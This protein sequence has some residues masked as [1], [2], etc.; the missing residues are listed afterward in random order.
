MTVSGPERQHIAWLHQPAYYY[1]MGMTSTSSV[2][3]QNQ[4]TFPSGPNTTSQRYR[5]F[6]LLVI[7]MQI[8]LSSLQKLPRLNTKIS[9]LLLLNYT[10]KMA[11]TCIIKYFVGNQVQ[12]AYYI[13]IILVYVNEIQNNNIHRTSI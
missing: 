10:L 11:Q 2:L 5:N 6:F 4:T 3:S 12:E 13:S 8:N 1:S 7:P 9:L